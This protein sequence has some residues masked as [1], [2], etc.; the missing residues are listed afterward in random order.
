MYLSFA[1]EL[2]SAL[3]PV[4][5]SPADEDD[6]DKKTLSPT[7]YIDIKSEGL[8]DILRKHSHGQYEPRQACCKALLRHFN[9][10][11]PLTVQI[12]QNLLYN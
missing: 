8:R 12:E 11:F 3:M 10:K 7:H 5:T 1:S 2:V 9:L 4:N 6:P